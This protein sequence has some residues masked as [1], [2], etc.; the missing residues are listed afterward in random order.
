MDKFILDNSEQVI[1]KV[2]DLIISIAK[3]CITTTGKFTIALSGGST[4]KLLY[5]KLIKEDLF[6]SID[7]A[8]V[9]VYF[10]D[11]RYVPL[12]DKRSNYGLAKENLLNFI[13]IP[14]EN[15]FPVNTTFEQPHDAASNYQNIISNNVNCNADN[16]PEF[17]LIILG[18]GTDGHTASLFPG[19]SIVTEYDDLV[20]SC[21]HQES[22]TERI[23]FT[24]PLINASKNIILITVGAE[25]YKVL[26]EI[27]QLNKNNIIKYPVQYVKPQGSFMWFSDT[28]AESGIVSS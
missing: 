18:M 14:T 6:K 2:S 8:K 24:F 12:D 10:S 26:S 28:L 27:A 16:I 9:F 20:A 3:Q 22:N 21:F 23:S 25:K 15:I 7:T 19:L 1:T 4:P 13:D 17:D 5:S 11:E